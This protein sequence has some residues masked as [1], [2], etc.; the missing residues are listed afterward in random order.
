MF[1]FSEKSVLEILTFIIFTLTIIIV[2][3][4]YLKDRIDKMIFKNLNHDNIFQ[5]LMEEYNYL[6]FTILLYILGISLGLNF[7]F[8]IVSVILKNNNDSNNNNGLVLTNYNTTNNNNN[9]KNSIIFLSELFNKNFYIFIF[10]IIIMFFFNLLCIYITY[11]SINSKINENS[12]N[13]EYK[14]YINEFNIYY[15]ILFYFFLFCILIFG[16]FISYLRNKI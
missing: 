8:L 7:I 3:E 15:R 13:E 14:S 11:K 6:P 9:K 2:T 5:S 1:V 16:Y 10:T 4:G 12:T